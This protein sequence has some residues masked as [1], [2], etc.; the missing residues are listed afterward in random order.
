VLGGVEG[1]NARTFE[2][3]ESAPME[4]LQKIKE[5]ASL[6][7]MAGAKYVSKLLLHV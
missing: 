2:H 4:L 3:K 6:W 7:A 5:D 1:K